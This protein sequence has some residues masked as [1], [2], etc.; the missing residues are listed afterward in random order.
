LS[1]DLPFRS[2]SYATDLF[3]WQQVCTTAYPPP[4]FPAPSF[5]VPFFHSQDST[6]RSFPSF[7]KPLPVTVSPLH[8]CRRS[9]FSLYN[10]QP[11]PPFVLPHPPTSNRRQRFPYPLRGTPVPRSLFHLTRS[12]FPLFSQFPQKTPG[13][14]GLSFLF[15]PFF[16]TRLGSRNLLLLSMSL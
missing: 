15:F 12:F 1:P 16:L 10:F 9:L 7:P 4:V 14:P 8:C 11:P 3:F 2:R 6:T 13:V 5:S